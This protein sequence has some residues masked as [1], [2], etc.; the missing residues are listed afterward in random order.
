MSFRFPGILL[1][2]F[3]IVWIGA[4]DVFA[5]DAVYLRGKLLTEKKEVLLSE[6]AKIPDRMQDKIVLRNLESPVL[7]R[8]EDI[9]KLFPNVSVSGKEL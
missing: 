1:F 5:M 2:A 7:I 3:G 9:Q 6:I 8:P 4:G